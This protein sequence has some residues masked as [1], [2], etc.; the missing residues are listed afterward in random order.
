MNLLVTGAAGFIG[1][2]VCEQIVKTGDFVIGI[3][4]FDNYYS[5]KQKRLNLANLNA[6]SNFVLYETDIRNKGRLFEVF[7]KN[8]IDIVLHLA[9]KAG[10]RPSL[11]NATDYY[12]VNV[13]GTLAILDAMKNFNV[14]KLLF[15]SSSSVY[16][17]NQKI[18][19]SESDQVDHPISPY[20]STKISGELLCHVY[21]HL[22]G[23][24][25]SCLRFFTVYGPRQRPDLAI[26][27]FTR[28]I[29]MG[30][31]IPIYGDGSTARDY[32]YIDDI[33]QGI[34]NA[35]KYLEGYRIYN[36][37][38]SRVIGLDKLV[39]TIEELL[40]KK[41]ILNRLPLQPGDMKVT[42]ADISKARNEIGYNP[43]YDFSDG[44]EKFIEWY[45]VNKELIY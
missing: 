26:H 28:M 16:G 14:R 29:D 4:N 45:R 41:A 8:K 27:K 37:G 18:P 24:D 23:F 30:I 5:T 42:Y 31:P 17:N 12:S 19:F 44:V 21:S 20:A 43:E 35:I 10:I 40:H 6:S 7:L 3:D 32:T 15:A 38:E 9:A 36:L 1:S 11:E 39:S 33:V 2:H 22:Y 25:V 13:D 34:M